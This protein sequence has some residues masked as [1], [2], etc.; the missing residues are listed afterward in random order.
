MS[1]ILPPPVGPDWK[2]WGRQLSTYL[3]RALSRM[4]F[5]VGDPVP[6]ENG[7]LLWDDVAGYPVVSKNGEFRQIILED[8]NYRG[9]ITSNV[10][11]AVAD[12]P[13][14]LTY[15]PTLANGVANDGTYP[16]RIVFAEAGEYLVNFSAQ[17]SSSTAAAVT[18]RFWPR[19]NGVNSSGAT[20]V[21]SLHNNGATF[22]ASR[23]AVFHVDAGDYLEAV[24]ATTDTS[25]FLDATA[26]TAYAPSA[27]AST[28]VITRIHG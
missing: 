3:G 1:A 11:A 19:I 14:E 8:G 7:I 21:C 6:S 18:F 10:T 9:T 2:V 4:Q 24:W 20:M 12:T 15:T 25:G 13:Y 17:F 23:A 5:K 27:P 28:I 16:S 26:A 22:A